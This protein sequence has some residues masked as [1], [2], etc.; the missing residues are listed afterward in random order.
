MPTK[1]PTVSQMHKKLWPLFSTY[2]RKKDADHR[3]H[4]FCCTCGS[5]RRWQEVDAGHFVS[6]G[7]KSLLYDERNVHAQC[8]RCNT[9]GGEPSAYA[10]FIIDKYGQSVLESLNKIKNEIKQYR[11]DELQDMVTL[12][13]KKLEDL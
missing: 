5:R 10:L 12:Y 9:M 3:G 4:I 13:K 6:R 1:K 11:V 7:H 2:I 8:K